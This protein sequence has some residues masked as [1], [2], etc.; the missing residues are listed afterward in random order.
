MDANDV[1]MEQFRMLEERRNYFGKL[2]WQLPGFFVGVF[3]VFIGLAD[4][5]HSR[6]L[7]TSYFVGGLIL[8]LISWIAHRLRA[9]QDECE[10]LIH[11]IEAK[12][13][14]AGLGSG[15]PMPRSYRVGARLVT[16]GALVISGV[17]LIVV[18]LAWDALMR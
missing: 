13:N 18:S 6:M 3:A 17:A 7:Q 14:A 12:L 8:L 2:F 4:K 16:V 5:S 15:I 11:Q 9:S 10:R 1:L